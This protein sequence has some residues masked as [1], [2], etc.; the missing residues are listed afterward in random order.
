MR[1]F[2]AVGA[3]KLHDGLAHGRDGSGQGNGTHVGPP[4]ILGASFFSKA[5]SAPRALASD[6]VAALVEVAERVE[7]HRLVSRR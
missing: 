5:S 2:A 4:A 7:G 3:F 1:E 6:A